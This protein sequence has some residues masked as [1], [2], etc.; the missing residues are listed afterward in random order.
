MRG[1]YSQWIGN[2]IFV[3]YQSDLDVGNLNY[4][5][6]VVYCDPRFDGMRLQYVLIDE[7][8]RF[9][10]T[11]QEMKRFTYIE[12]AAAKS[13]KHPIYVVFVMKSD[14]KRL[15]AEIAGYCEFCKRYNWV[16][17]VFKSHHEALHWLARQKPLVNV[18]I[19]RLEATVR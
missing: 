15:N 18:D 1:I 19:K 11:E 10:V 2:N 6:D 9:N 4:F 12:E 3:R 16:G 8:V 17:K 7:G 5:H 13:N 14:D